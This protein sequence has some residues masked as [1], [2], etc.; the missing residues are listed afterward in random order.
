MSGR[1][2]RG[3]WSLA[4]HGLEAAL[5]LARGVMPIASQAIG[6]RPGHPPQA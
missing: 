3:C 2:G 4:V 5:V 1:D 6:V